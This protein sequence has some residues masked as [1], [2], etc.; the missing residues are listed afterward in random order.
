MKFHRHT[1]THTA[2]VTV[3][4]LLAAWGLLFLTVLMIQP[5]RVTRPCGCSG[6][7]SC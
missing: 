7:T 4:S 6:R 2:L 5:G 1:V 3:I